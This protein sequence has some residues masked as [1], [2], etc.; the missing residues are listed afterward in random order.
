MKFWKQTLIAAFVFL[1]MVTLIAYTACEKD[2]CSNLS[3]KNGGSCAAG[4][5][6]CPIGYQGHTCEVKMSS[7]FVGAYAGV[8]Q[9]SQGNGITEGAAVIDTVWVFAGGPNGVNSLGVIQ[10]TNGKNDTL[11]GTAFYNQ[12]IY[13]I[14]IPKDTMT[15]ISKT[16]TVTLQSNS[17]L[18][19]NSYE[20][21]D[22]TAGD[23]II[24]NCN[25]NGFKFK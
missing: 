1:T 7:L 15:N 8:T 6:N 23:T 17:K 9:C 20:V 19:V 25:F 18:T 2:A 5:C 13:G 4:T 21:N 12:S 14:S 3:C 22:T 11:Y 16:F 10:L 24:E